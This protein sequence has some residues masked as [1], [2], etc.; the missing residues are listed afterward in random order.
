MRYSWDP[1][2]GR[3]TGVQAPA[4]GVAETA[5]ALLAG[6]RPEG[7]EGLDGVID[8]LVCGHGRRDRCCGS[9][10]TELEAQL[11]VAK[12]PGTARV[13]RT[14]HTGGHRF[15]PTAIALPHGTCWGYLDAPALVAITTRTD[16]PTTFAGRYRGCMGMSSPAVQALE[17]A[18]LATE[19]WRVL[20]WPR[21]GEEI[22]DGVVELVAQTTEGERRWRGVVDVVRILP[23]PTCGQPLGDQE[24]TEAE[25]TVVGLEE[26]AGSPGPERR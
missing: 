12:L 6:E 16:P 17:R 14:S 25:L 22:G 13:W 2:R 8:L 10:G 15:A 26:L 7:T 21:R 3:F 23:V 4:D 9:A 24:K 19:G 18:V 20:D 5:L 11:R 1:D